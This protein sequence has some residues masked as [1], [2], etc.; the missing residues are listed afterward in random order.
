MPQALL[1]T[2]TNVANKES[3]PEMAKAIKEN[4]IKASNAGSGLSD[5]GH[6]AKDDPTQEGA[7]N[8]AADDFSKALK[9]TENDVS[10]WG[11]FFLYCC[12]FFLSD[13]VD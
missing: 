5:A 3:N 8:N 6:R 12:S 11:C 13:H 10:W 2:G 4:L 7:F 1:T 9:V